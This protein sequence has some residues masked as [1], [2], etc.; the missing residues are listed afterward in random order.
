MWFFSLKTGVIARKKP[1]NITFDNIMETF[2]N[3]KSKS[4]IAGY[5][6]YSK[7]SKG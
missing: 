5:F 4:G 1:A 6:L 2:T 3:N 7:D